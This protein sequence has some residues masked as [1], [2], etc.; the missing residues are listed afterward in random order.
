[1]ITQSTELTKEMVEIAE[2]NG[3]LKALHGQETNHLIRLEVSQSEENSIY[4]HKLK[5][6]GDEEFEKFDALCERCKAIAWETIAK[7][8]TT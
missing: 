1:M 5:G 4:R 8:R 6:T 3:I 7:F 2:K